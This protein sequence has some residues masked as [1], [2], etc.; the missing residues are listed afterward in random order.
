MAVTV[1]KVA[2]SKIVYL[3]LLLLRIVPFSKGEGFKTISGMEMIKL[4]IEIL[5]C[6]DVLIMH[7]FKIA[8]SNWNQKDR[9]F[10][11]I[12]F[13]WSLTKLG[14]LKSK[15]KFDYIYLSIFM[16]T[17]FQSSFEE[18]TLVSFSKVWYW[19]NALKWG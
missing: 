15:Q 14:S 6:C 16:S 7:I 10:D 5:S 19:K 2:K 4:N 17:E 9:F 8:T 13:F 18:L 12:S 3:G 11:V 1:W